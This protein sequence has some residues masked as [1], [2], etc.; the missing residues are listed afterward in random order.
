MS[1]VNGLLGWSED[2]HDEKEFF[3]QCCC[4]YRSD[5]VLPILAKRSDNLLMWIEDKTEVL[6]LSLYWYKYM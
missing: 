6:L 3:Q 2:E 4:F 5:K 1:S